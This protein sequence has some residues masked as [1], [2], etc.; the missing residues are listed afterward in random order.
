MGTDSHYGAGR[1]TE[2]LFRDRTHNEVFHARATMGREDNQVDSVHLRNAFDDVPDET[3]PDEFLVS[4][5][6]KQST[7]SEA[8]H[9]PFCFSFCHNVAFVKRIQRNPC[10]WFRLDCVKHNDL[11]SM[12]MGKIDGVFQ[13]SFRPFAEVSCNEDILQSKLRCYLRVSHGVLHRTQVPVGRLFQGW[14]LPR[15]SREQANV[16]PR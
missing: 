13:G 4:K 7:L 15:D 5:T 9:L 3:A 16:R 10:E 8:R 12:L 11:R 2:Y 6:S 1:T 14:R